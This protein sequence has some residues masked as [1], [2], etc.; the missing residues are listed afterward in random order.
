MKRIIVPTDFSEQASYAFDLACQIAE[1]SQAEIIALHVL[2][3][4]GFMDF[5]IGNGSYPVMG[6]PANFGYDGKLIETLQSQAKENLQAFVDKYKGGKVGIEQ[7][8]RLGSAFN[9]ISEEINEEKTDLVVMGSKG[10]G[11]LE[12]ALIGSNTEK[13]V[14]HAKSPV[15]T[16]KGPTSL[17]SISD[18][19]FAS[20]F[21]DDVS[22]VADDLKK[23]QEVFKA[24][25]H[26]VRINTP[27]NFETTRKTLRLIDAFIKE[28]G[29]RNCAVSIYNDKVEEDGIIY[30]AEDIDADLIALATHGRS[31]LLHLLSGS[32]AEDVVN[33]AKRPVWTFR[34]RHS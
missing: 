3:Y 7:K 6:N 16:V 10:A 31:G 34:L 14:R 32:I 24:K 12:E 19:A 5:N 33:H 26:L 21:S 20:D 22:H 2:D 25:L 1:A 18:I 27:N 17:K 23:L 15:L 9:L 29:L 4:T 8:V 11:G 13:V 30:F 28:N